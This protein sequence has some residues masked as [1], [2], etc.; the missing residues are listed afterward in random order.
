M[1]PDVKG[2]LTELT[3]SSESSAAKEFRSKF[4]HAVVHLQSFLGTHDIGQLYYQ[5]IKD[6]KTGSMIIVTVRSLEDV[7][8]VSTTHVK[9][10]SL[11][12]LQRRLTSVSS[13]VS[14]DEGHD[15]DEMDD[16]EGCLYSDRMVTKRDQQVQQQGA[17]ER[18]ISSTLVSLF[19]SRKLICFTYLLRLH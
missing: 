6:P 16:N 1:W 14:R 12:K 18:L 19:V 8:S 7:K 3:K 17:I 2:L 5:P 11:T 4:I 9:W 10:M 13:V 15:P